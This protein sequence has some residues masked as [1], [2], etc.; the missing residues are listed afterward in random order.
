MWIPKRARDC[1]QVDSVGHAHSS[2][3]VERRLGRVLST[4]RSSVDVILIDGAHVMQVKIRREALSAL[5]ND[6]PAAGPS[7][8]LLGK[9]SL[10]R[11]AQTTKKRSSGFPQ[12]HKTTLENTDCCRRHQ[13]GGIYLYFYVFW[14]CLFICLFSWFASTPVCRIHTH[15]HAL[16][17]EKQQ[18]S[19]QVVNQHGS[20]TPKLAASV[21]THPK[22]TR[23]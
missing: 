23:L 18:K 20:S 4:I 12:T 9:T 15:R 13:R 11:T 7:T 2:G 19:A 5:P 17:L 8:C 1:W 21:Q 3:C 14:I 22:S 10:L 6:F 16:I